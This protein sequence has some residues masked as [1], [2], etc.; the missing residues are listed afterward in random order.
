MRFLRFGFAF[1]RND[2]VEA[3]DNEEGNGGAVP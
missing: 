3:T 2:N 1:G